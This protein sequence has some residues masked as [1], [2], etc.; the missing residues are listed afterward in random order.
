[1]TALIAAL[2]S[3]TVKDAGVAKGF[4]ED[5]GVPSRTLRL[6]GKAFGS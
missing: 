2:K 1:M 6:C 3:L 5:S 4:F